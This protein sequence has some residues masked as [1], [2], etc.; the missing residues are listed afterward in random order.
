MF[1]I[2]HA[3]MCFI[4]YWSQ[5]KIANICRWHFVMFWLKFHWSSS[6]YGWHR[7]ISIG[8]G[9]DLA[10]DRQQ[11]IALTIAHPVHWH[12][13]HDQ[14]TNVNSLENDSTSNIVVGTLLH[15]NYYWSNNFLSLWLVIFVPGNDHHSQNKEELLPTYFD[16][17][18][19]YW[20]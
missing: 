7:K 17:H 15:I 4:N 18:I 13:R 8:S 19:T 2:K 11:A 9:N 16:Y 1:I 6:W 14:V 5:N 12:I 10:L 20:T 3:S